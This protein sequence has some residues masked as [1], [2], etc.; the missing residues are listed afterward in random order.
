V[1]FS[2]FLPILSLILVILMF[3]TKLIV[4]RIVGNYYHWNTPYMEG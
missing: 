2:I 4:S 1:M 3:P